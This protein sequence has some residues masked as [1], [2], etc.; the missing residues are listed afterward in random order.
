MTPPPWRYAAAD[1]RVVT[2]VWPG[3]RV[4]SC[5]ADSLPPDAPT[6]EPKD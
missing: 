1:R 6:P 4:D 5:L 3:G 2:R